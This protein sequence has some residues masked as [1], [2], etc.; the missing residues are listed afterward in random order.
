MWVLIGEILIKPNRE[1][2]LEGKTF[3]ILQKILAGTYVINNVILHRQIIDNLTSTL[4]FSV[5][6]FNIVY[7]KGKI[8]MF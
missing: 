1:F 5:Y 6:N 2:T 4:A 3:Y 8:E 7:Q